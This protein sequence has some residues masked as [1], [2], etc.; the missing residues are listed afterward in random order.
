V[1]RAAENEFKGII[2]YCDEQVV[3]SDFITTEWSCIYDS[4]A[5]ISLN[6]HFVNSLPG[7]WHLCVT[8]NT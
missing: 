2:H 3:S 4:L 1:K 8:Y 5:G 6:S 7:Q